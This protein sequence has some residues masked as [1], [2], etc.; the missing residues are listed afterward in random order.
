[1]LSGAGEGRG[2]AWKRQRAA[3]CDVA[4]DSS[5]R[6]R[7]GAIISAGGSTACRHNAHYHNTLLYS[8]NYRPHIVTNQY[9][10]PTLLASGFT[11]V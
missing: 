9:Q 3:C 8:K 2:A 10:I 1:M 4:C 5:A 7:P 6:S 11:Q